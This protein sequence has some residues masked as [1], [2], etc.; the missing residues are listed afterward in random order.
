MEQLIAWTAAHWADVLAIYGGVVALATVIVKLT[1]SAKDDEILARVVKF[2]DFF[3]T[4][5]PKKG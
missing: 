1:P 5:N 3:S 2:L 4:V